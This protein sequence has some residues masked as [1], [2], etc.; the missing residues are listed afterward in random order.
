MTLWRSFA[1]LRPLAAIRGACVSLER[2]EV[3]LRDEHARDFFCLDSPS[4]VGLDLERPVSVDVPKVRNSTLNALGAPGH[5]HHDFG[6][7]RDGP[8]QQLDV[9]MEAR[10]VRT[11]HTTGGSD[12]EQRLSEELSDLARHGRPPSSPDWP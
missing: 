7:V 12:V 10:S 3:P 1:G 5:L 8:R 11:T 9:S 2:L 4:L 6:G